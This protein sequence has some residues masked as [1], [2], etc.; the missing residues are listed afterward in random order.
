M[1]IIQKIDFLILNWL[2]KH[3]R[4]KTLDILMPM[5]TALGNGGFLFALL[6]IGLLCTRR[7]RRE[8]VA[9]G[10][11]LLLCPLAGNLFLKPLVGR[12][13][14]YD[15]VDGF[16]LLIKPLPDY[17]FPSGHTMAAF[18]CAGVFW[19]YRQM[20]GGWSNVM[21][22]LAVLMGFSRLY[23]YVHFPTDILGGVALGLALGA[24]GSLLADKISNKWAK[25]SEVKRTV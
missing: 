5:I 9:V 10:T 16:Q 6:T 19:H 14:P 21:M 12:I 15:L 13:R 20:F 23:L 7:W 3:L 2:Q 4:G 11:S 18:A 24:C 8:G 1:G 25:R 17:S 22:G